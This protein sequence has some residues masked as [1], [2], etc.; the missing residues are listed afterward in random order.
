MVA[1]VDPAPLQ[2]QHAD[3]HAHLRS[4]NQNGLFQSGFVES[5]S[6]CLE[7]GHSLIMGQVVSFAHGTANDRL[8][9]TLGKSDNVGLEGSEI[10]HQL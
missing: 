8:H 2:S 10:W 6:G 5:F 7:K 1:R 3:E 9:A 4:S